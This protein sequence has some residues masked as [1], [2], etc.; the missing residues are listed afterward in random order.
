MELCQSSNAVPLQYTSSLVAFIVLKFLFI[1]KSV[2]NGVQIML[3]LYLGL[4]FENI[5]TESHT[6]D[7]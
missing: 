1:Y 2:Y 6:I 3:C 7:S 5:L 4:F